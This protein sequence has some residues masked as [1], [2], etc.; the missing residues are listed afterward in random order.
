[1]LQS[2]LDACPGI[3][4][5][6]SPEGVITMANREAARFFG[7]KGAVGRS[8]VETVHPEDR[9]AFQASW[10]RLPK[11]GEAL[12]AVSRLRGADGHDQ[13]FSWSARRVSDGPAIHAV[14]LP[15]AP[16]AQPSEND[17][18]RILRV[19]LDN[20]DIAVTVVDRNGYVTLNDGKSLITSGLGPNFNLGKHLPEAYAHDP[21]IL[22]NVERALRG[23]DRHYIVEAHG[24]LWENWFSPVKNADG[25][26]VGA[27]C[28][29]C[30][31]SESKRAMQ[32]MQN[33]LHLIERQQEVIRNLE[34][35]IIEV[36]DRVVT[37]PMVGVVDSARA[38]RVMDDLLTAVSRQSA[39]YAILDL[40]GVEIVDTATAAHILSLISAIRLLGAEGIITGIRPTVAQT[41]VS[42]GLDLSRVITCANLREG[43]RLCIR[44]MH[45]QAQADAS[46]G[47]L[48]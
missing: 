28:L 9:G 30:D 46:V 48:V 11:D 22:E 40:T 44:R 6:T 42:L 5:V 36:W 16:A 18:E 45:A 23:E 3:Y 4:F 12:R 17:P 20:L 13:A 29:S 19:L 37:L 27:I 35:P 43:L 33:R 15:A 2:F 26:V 24:V 8:L 25:E 31:K 41:V 1:M 7:E 39:R 10:A 14:L 34:T 32:D 38:A 21:V 47:A